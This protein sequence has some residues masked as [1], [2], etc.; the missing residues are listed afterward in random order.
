MFRAKV[1]NLMTAIGNFS[2]LPVLVFAALSAAPFLWSTAG[3][4]YRYIGA[5]DY[6][7]PI[8]SL[9]SFH[10]AIYP[11]DQLNGA[12][13]E[14]PYVVAMLP[15]YLFYYIMDW[16]EA[17]PLFSTIF[18]LSLLIFV[19]EIAFFVSLKYFL[20][21]KLRYPRE[22]TV[23]CAI[24][25]ILYGFS[26]YFIAQVLPG[27]GMSLFVYALFPLI[28]LYLDALMVAVKIDY[29]AAIALFVTLALC[30][31]SFANIGI[32]YVFLIAGAIYALLVTLVERLDIWRSSVHFTVFVVL[33]FI[34]NAWWLS[35]H[36]YN[37]QRYIA[38]S[39][40]Y[41]GEMLNLVGFASKDAT[42]ANIFQGKPEST[43]YM[44]DILGHNYYINMFQS[45]IF[46]VITLLVIRAAFS[47]QRQIH[48]LLFAALVSIMFLKG[49]QA[50]F[51]D[52]F[53]W[54]Y[55]N[56][57]G[58]Q[59]MR[60]P[61]AKFYG[62]FLFFFLACATFELATIVDKLNNPRWWA[63]I[64][65]GFLGVAAV[66]MVLI[67]SLTNSLKPFNIPRMYFETRDYLMRDQVERALILPIVSGVRPHYR[68]TMNSY[69]GMDFVNE[70]FRF[71][72]IAPHSVDLSINE[73]YLRPTNE[74]IQ[75]I[76][77]NKSICETSRALG[78]SHIVVRDDL[79][80]SSV[81]DAPRLIAAILDKH[82]D[83]AQRTAFADKSGA[84]LIVYK[85][86]VE[87]TGNLLNLDGKFVSFKY[88]L[89]NPGKIVL[90]I[91]GLRGS[92]KLTFLDDYSQ[93]WG[94]FVEQPNEP[95]KASEDRARSSVAAAYNTPGVM[96]LSLDEVRYLFKRMPFE[97]SHVVS[98]YAN[99]WTVDPTLLGNKSGVSNGSSN[100][101]DSVNVKLVL[102]YRP[103]V[104]LLLGIVG[105]LAT[106]FL[107]LLQRSRKAMLRREPTTSH[108]L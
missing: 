56:I 60:R 17:T 61:T 92:A 86:K 41:G 76:R 11:F 16:L 64:L 42:I 31:P 95:T 66:Y 78:I 96:K 68:Y 105:S 69:S 103:Q 63:H 57:P 104:Y 72:K 75:L 4:D 83:I 12:G 101:D 98:Q 54:V 70:L 94:V 67:F 53:L 80:H 102:Y 106:L 58:F 36:L 32:L 2:F 47:R 30:S 5:D 9:I 51:S 23:A 1:K 6:L 20:T 52:L 85:L 82:P 37:L 21:H 108:G 28:I 29:T 65:L 7:S 107:L 33:A 87:C 90:N 81:Q 59:V 55:N 19:A 3:N 25:A 39:K 84:E 48:A 15:V 38:A 79:V 40:T 93:N 50:P 45:L 89:L 14:Q 43:I 97:S 26:P 8:N 18:L 49:V 73:G 24:G 99:A 22:S 91:E 46:L 77:D 34:S 27:H 88:E 35:P 71:P 10:Y 74:L 62:F 13:F 100:S 44:I